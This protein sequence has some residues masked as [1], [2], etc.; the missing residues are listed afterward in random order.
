MNFENREENRDR[1]VKGRRKEDKERER[2]RKMR[3][4]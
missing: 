1:S 3:T 2:R 4:H